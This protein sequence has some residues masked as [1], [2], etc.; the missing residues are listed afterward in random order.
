MKERIVW[1]NI[2]YDWLA[3]H[4]LT[5]LTKTP[6]SNARLLP[7]HNKIW[8]MLRHCSITV[9]IVTR[10]LVRRLVSMVLL[11]SERKFDFWTLALGIVASSVAKGP[12]QSR[13]LPPPAAGVRLVF[14]E[15]PR[16]SR[17]FRFNFQK[18]LL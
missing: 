9:G 7:A 16:G 3:A 18:V 4:E 6:Y 17:A 8:M 12:S 11:L 2:N 5:F 10:Q 13:R 14:V 1:T 15:L